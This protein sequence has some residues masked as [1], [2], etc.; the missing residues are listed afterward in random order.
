[1][2]VSNNSYLCFSSACCIALYCNV[3]F[4]TVF[5]SWGD[6]VCIFGYLLIQQGENIIAGVLA[7]DLM[8]RKFEWTFILSTCSYL[9]AV[10][11]IK[12]LNRI[13]SAYFANYIVLAY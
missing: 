8:Q 13:S 10:N 11:K 4:A 2:R 12:L 5:F 3:L 7:G 9:N 1:M 6:D